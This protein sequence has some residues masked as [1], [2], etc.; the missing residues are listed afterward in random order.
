MGGWALLEIDVQGA[1]QIIRQYPQALT[2]F[3]RTSSEAEYEKRLRGRGTD[4]EEIIERRLA[5][6]RTE[7]KQ[8]PQYRFQVVNDNLDRAVEEIVNIISSWRQ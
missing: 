7:L 6:A 3:L 4:S 1:E 8:A 5:N 2:I